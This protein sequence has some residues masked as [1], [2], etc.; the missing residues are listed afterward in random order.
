MKAGRE[1]DRKIAEFRGCHVYVSGNQEY[2]EFKNPKTG[3]YRV[4]PRYST[5]IAAAWEV[6]EK[7]E[8]QEIY[9]IWDGEDKLAELYRHGDVICEARS[10]SLPEAICLAA[11]KVMEQKGKDD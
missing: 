3:K 6:V 4:L 10:K 8:T 5:D 2:R 7:L 1:L 9:L 11:L